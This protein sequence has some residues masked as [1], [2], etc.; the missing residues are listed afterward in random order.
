MQLSV[1]N[2]LAKSG[3]ITGVIISVDPSDERK[4]TVVDLTTVFGKT[5][6]LTTATKKPRYFKNTIQAL[7]TISSQTGELKNVKGKIKS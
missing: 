1:F 2:E 6:R 4:R 3:A 5:V 7:D